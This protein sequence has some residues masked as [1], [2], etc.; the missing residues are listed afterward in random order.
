MQDVTAIE[1]RLFA[2]KRQAALDTARSN[3]ANFVL[4][5]D[6]TYTMKWYHRILANALERVARGTL[7]RLMVNMPPRHGKSQLVSRLFPAYLLGRNP[8]QKVI[9]A[10]Y[11]AELASLMN[12]DVQRVIDSP[13]YQEVYPATKLSTHNARSVSGKALRNSDMFEIVEHSGSYRGVGVGGGVTGM[14]GEKIILDDV[15]KSEE[16]A[17]SPTYRQKTWDWYTNTLLTRQQYGACV[18]LCMTRWHEDDLAGRIL[19]RAIEDPKADQWEVINYPAIREDDSN[20]D[21]P[22]QIGEALWPEL[23]DLE[24]LERMRASMGDAG[25]VG[26]YQQRPAVVGGAIFKSHRWCFYYRGNEPPPVLARTEDGSMVACYQERLPA[27]FDKQWQSWDM[28]FKDSKTSDFV[29]GQV[30]AKLGAR[31][32]LLDQVRARM[33]FPRTLDAVAELS[34]KWPKTRKKL[35]EDKANGPAVMQ[36]AKL[37]IPGMDAVNPEG[38]KEARANAIAPFQEAQNLFLPHPN[39]QPWIR[40]F[41]SECEAFPRGKFDDQVDCYTQGINWGFGGR[42]VGKIR[43]SSGW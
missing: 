11:N 13:N 22:R 37:K 30:H 9:C 7:R 3:F 19:Q 31:G 5:V 26:L 40:G 21:D 15:V 14:G 41:L 10:S 35:I 24:Y 23:Y 2:L 16:E 12:R 27:T 34:N 36:T 6:R 20:P 4:W 39:E 33:D 38:G 1:A 43:V 28:T 25:F 18:V 29:V 42:R 17:R 8:H 32:Y